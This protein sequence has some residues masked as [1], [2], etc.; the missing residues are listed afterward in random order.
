MPAS[1][2]LRDVRAVTAEKDRLDAD[3]SGYFGGFGGRYVPEVLIP[4]LEDLQQA[5]LEAKADPEFAAQ[6]AHLLAT[7]AGR[8]TPL[9]FAERLTES[10]GGARIYLKNEGVNITGAHKI[11]HCLGQALLAKRMGARGWSPR[12]EPGSTGSLPPRWPPSSGSS[13][14]STWARWILRASAPTS[15]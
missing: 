3:A 14:R 5:Y 15:S 1:N 11:T 6:F 9:T 10:L 8:P 4:A 12:P 2:A 7:F 13:A